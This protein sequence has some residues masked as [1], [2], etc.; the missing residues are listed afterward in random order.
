MKKA[1][2]YLFGFLFITAILTYLSLM[3]F[4]H[5]WSD[6]IFSLKIVQKPFWHMLTIIFN[7]DSHPVLY[8]TLL[9]GWT[10]LFGNSI[11]AARLL[12]LIGLLSLGLLALYPIKRLAGTSVALWFTALVFFSP[13]SF[14]VALDIR[15]YSWAAFFVT[16]ALIYAC[17]I[18][19]N[20][21]KRGDWLF[22][23]LFTLCAIYTHHYAMIS[24]VFIYIG[25]FI[26]LL[27]HKENRIQNMKRFFICGFFLFLAAIPDLYFLILHTIRSRD[28]LFIKLTN[29]YDAFFIFFAL[30]RIWVTNSHYPMVLATSTAW[31]I[32][33]LFI[34][35]YKKFRTDPLYKYVFFALLP[36]LGIILIGGLGSLLYRP[37][38][39]WRYM[40]PGMGC[41]SLAF[42]IA[43]S[44]QKTIAGIFGFLFFLSF[45]ACAW[46]THVIMSDTEQKRLNMTLREKIKPN[47]VIIASS[48]ASYFHL[49]YFFPDYNFY[50]DRLTANKELLYLKEDIRII[51]KDN[52]NE[53]NTA[54]VLWGDLC[55]DKGT[56]FYDR[57]VGQPYCLTVEHFSLEKK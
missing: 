13:W 56:F 9:K 20:K 16:A 43:L 3:S 30:P 55:L 36:I 52:L 41:C 38:L 35:R 17:L 32:T 14:W 2:P 57:Y 40:L 25:L 31:L 19:S 51:R 24:C 1:I 4:T 47:E 48:L 23:T 10:L 42:A 8:Y 29:T 15:M 7:E 27:Y 49:L 54:H 33:F 39:L 21:T 50:L 53:Q 44:R 11:F 26:G 18:L 28:I 46:N 37:I 22:L 12:S 5:V 6:E 45:I 34:Y